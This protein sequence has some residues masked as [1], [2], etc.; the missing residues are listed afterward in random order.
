[1]RRRP[2]IAKVEI[3]IVD[4]HDKPDE[5]W[6]FSNANVKADMGDQSPRVTRE[7][8][9]KEQYREGGNESLDLVQWAATLSGD[10]SIACR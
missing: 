2:R 4:V 9:A 7:A 1:M 8:D 3:K 5:V 6:I 10:V